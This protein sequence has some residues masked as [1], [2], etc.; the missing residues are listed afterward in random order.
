MSQRF[1]R[2]ALLAAAAIG[3]GA[4]G[5][6]AQAPAEDSSYYELPITARAQANSGMDVPLNTEPTLPIPTGH[7]GDAGFYTS[8]EFVYLTQTRTM[9]DQTVA[10]RGL[11][12][13]TGRITGI[14]GAYIG[15]RQVAL[16]TDMLGR[17]TYSP[18]YRVELGYK[19]DDGFQL[20]A[21]YL[22]MFDAH[23]SAG[24]T[25]V[26]PYFRSNR[27]LTDT[28]LTAGVYNFSPKF[29]GPAHKTA[30]D[31]VIEGASL[32]YGIWNGA[33]TMDI[34]FTQRYTQAD[35]GGRMPLFQTDYS[36]VYGKAGG[37]FAWFFER[38]QWITRSFERDGNSNPQDAAFYTNTLSQR[39]YGP[40]VGCGHEIFLANQFSL[41]VDLDGAMLLGVVKERVKYELGDRST[42]AKRS[43]N[44][45]AL[46]PNA[47]A[48]VNL[49]WY[50]VEGVQVRVGYQGMAY[51]NT[52]NMEEPIGFDMG[53]MDPR[54]D[55]QYFRLLHGFNFGVGLFF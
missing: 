41:S 21:N 36:R 29:A 9:G 44:E 26:P 20:F 27:D 54:Y 5:S 1:I 8:M 40:F 52:R 37:R 48:A 35:V 19:F 18:G 32:T 53:A 43:N 51:F 38:F 25:S 30:Y 45:W 33:T 3:L 22:Q 7:A 46:V 31:P 50:P 10:Y 24:A 16:S 28:F 55:V 47:N 12:D 13:S 34:K 6:R 17:T 14:P 42:A 39:L 2:G 49:W 11:I 4:G 15:S 23:Y